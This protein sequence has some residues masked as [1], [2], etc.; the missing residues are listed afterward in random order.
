VRRNG[1]L[2]NIQKSGSKKKFLHPNT[3]YKTTQTGS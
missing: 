3:L 1:S 2:M